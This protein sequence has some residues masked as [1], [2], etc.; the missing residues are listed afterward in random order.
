[1]SVVNAIR[2]LA[3]IASLA[4]V[5]V[6]SATPANAASLTVGEY[7]ELAGLAAAGD[8]GA[9]DALTLYATGLLN[10]AQTFNETA[11]QA[12]ATPSI[13]L[14]ARVQPAALLQAMDAELKARPSFWQE[15]KNEDAGFAALVVLK[16]NGPCK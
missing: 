7:R 2:W 6:A 9:R 13:C 3:G 15:K 4:S 11:R 14:S 10:A 8:R 5:A 1:M 16:E 12:G